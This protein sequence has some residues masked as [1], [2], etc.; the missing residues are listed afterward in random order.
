MFALS[1]ASEETTISPVTVKSLLIVVSPLNFTIK[2]SDLAS[3]VPFPITKALFV[4][5]KP[6][7]EPELPSVPVKLYRPITNDE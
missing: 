2:A 1:L 6:V 7:G 5:K 3:A 4:V